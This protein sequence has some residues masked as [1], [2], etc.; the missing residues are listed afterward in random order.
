MTTET[1]PPRDNIVRAV[2]PGPAFHAAEGATDG[3][4]GTMHGEFA[5]FDQ[6]TRIDSITEGTFMERVAPGAFTKTFA[7][8]RPKVL[9]Q[10][11]KDP[12]VGDKPMGPIESLTET[13]TGAE[14]DVPLLDTSYNRDILPGLEAGLYGASFRFSVVKDDFNARPTRSAYNPDAIPER[15]IREARVFEFGPVTFPAYIG[16]T[17]GVRSLTD[18]YVIEQLISDPEKLTRLIASMKMRSLEDLAG[19]LLADP[20]ALQTAI[21][22][23]GAGEPLAANEAE[24]LEAAIEELEPPDCCQCCAAGCV[25]CSGYTCDGAEC[26]AMANAPSTM[27]AEP[28]EYAL[29]KVGAERVAHSSPVSRADPSPP[30]AER[31]QPVDYVS[32]EDKASR[33]TELKDGLTRQAQE[34]PGVLPI[35][36]QATWDADTK[37]LRDLEAD[38][39]AWDARQALVESLSG[40]EPHLERTYTPPPVNV[41]R[42][43]AVEDIYN[44]DQFT[45]IGYRT[46]EERN[47]T[48]RDNALRS[49]ES[50]HLNVPDKLAE[51]LDRDRLADALHRLAQLPPGL[52]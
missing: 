10:H 37:E 49:L 3:R 39:A 5:V 45:G 47:Q 17:A 36:A 50:T 28:T 33:V 42:R 43:K 12:Q 8:N 22:K 6:W 4:I 25:C 41:V 48:L 46:I 51:L 38:I 32:R 40:S 34:F 30:P 52:R 19:S 7:E 27:V 44:P 20:V 11:G 23:L 35:D 14:Y 26:C 9:F 13:K 2:F 31:N 1:R 24:L 15:T 29:P 18:T 16:A 21:G